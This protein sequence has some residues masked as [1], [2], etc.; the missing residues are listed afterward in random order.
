MNIK[1]FFNILRRRKWV[2][3]QA[4]I[5]IIGAT[6]ALTYL[7]PPVYETYAKLLIM[8]TPTSSS[9]SLI[10][11]TFKD[12]GSLVTTGSD[13]EVNTAIAMASIRP[14]VEGVIKK[15]DLK[16]KN[17][18]PMQPDK[19][20]K[21]GILSQILPLPTV[22]IAR[23]GDTNLFTITCNTKNPKLSQGIAN[24]LAEGI[25]EYSLNHVREEYASARAFIDDQIEKVNRDYLTYL[26]NFKE[27]KEKEQT[28]DLDSEI[29][30]AITKLA[31]LYQQKEDN[32]ID[33]EQSK[34]KLR[35]LKE[36]VGKMDTTRVL[37]NVMTE[38]PMV[39]LQ[40]EKITELELQLVKATLELK[41]DHP[42]VISIRSQ[43]EKAKEDL[44]KEVA[45]YQDS[46][47]LLSGLE[48]EIASL[49]VHL[50]G[51]NADI[52]KYSALFK[53]LPEKVMKY[54]K[55][56]LRLTVAE[57]I[58]KFLLQR[59]NEIGIAEAT[60]LSNIRIV[61]PA[62]E[63]PLGMP[64]KPK[65]VLNFA[66]GIILGL[67]SSVGLALLFENLDTTI[68]TTEDIEKV[69]N[70]PFLGVIPWMKRSSPHIISKRKLTDPICE[71]YRTI[72]NSISF[73][74]LDK[75]LR[76]ILITSAGPKEGKTL[77]A[78][79]L[80]IALA[81][82]GKRV[83]LIDTDLRRPNVHKHFNIPNTVGITNVLLGEK[84]VNDA[85]F[86]TDLEGLSVLPSGPIPPDPARLLE[87]QKMQQ[88]V[89]DLTGKYDI[90][91]LDS[92]P[93]LVVDDAI[94]I[95]RYMDGVVNVV[96]SGRSTIQT[97]TQM[98]EILRVAKAPLLGAVLNKQRILNG[99]Y[100]YYRYYKYYGNGSEPDIGKKA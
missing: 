91:V 7:I 15:Y 34:A 28:V 84:N 86:N 60:T 31:E 74:S 68:K 81:R 61:D 76:R 44:A 77:T 65:K 53:T 72:R 47:L 12:F 87:S 19:L 93:A 8:T 55:L 71:S 48:R 26:S 2:A 51:V 89:T 98:G 40:R 67:L 41:E 32:V 39:R 70:V 27:F 36:Q 23:F 78:V 80:S 37:P 57:N 58:Y 35:V 63:L 45:V 18:N 1:E 29:K 24:S 56:Q 11:S 69:E 5:V 64:T 20:L 21:P 6:T 46:N 100:G 14:I 38:N 94:F 82:E 13:T 33:L 97:V 75:P 79:N 54:A 73:S 43:L 10:S 59:K 66:I 25:V 3:I 22:S 4:F 52:D 95:S 90:L 42:E 88:L 96:E 92:A 50:A 16:D 17:G 49:E 30:V 83:L 85:I 9:S 62:I 99:G